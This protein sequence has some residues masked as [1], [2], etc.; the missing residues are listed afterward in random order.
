MAGVNVASAR[1]LLEAEGYTYTD[2]NSLVLIRRRPTRGW[3][4]ATPSG[5]AVDPS[6][7]PR[8]RPL[9]G[10][11]SIYWLAFENPTHDS[12]NH[13]A[14][15]AANLNG[16]NVTVLVELDVSRDTPTV[17]RQGKVEGGV[18][19]PGDIGTDGWLSCMASGGA[20]VAT[21]CAFTNCGWGHCAAA[22]GAAVAAG[23]TVGWLWAAFGW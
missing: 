4:E 10:I 16:R 1:A 5:W 8:R 12:A 11:D 19:I 2:T 6:R 9:T 13:T 17:I 23:C 20:G 18:F 14:V 3:A 7:L 15:L 21:G 22:G